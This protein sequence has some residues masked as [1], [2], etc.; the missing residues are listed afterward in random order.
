VDGGDYGKHYA[1]AYRRGRYRNITGAAMLDRLGNHVSARTEQNP[2]PGRPGLCPRVR[3]PDRRYIRGQSSAVAEIATSEDVSA[4]SPRQDQLNDGNAQRADS[5]GI[6]SL[7]VSQPDASRRFL[8]SMRTVVAG[9]DLIR[10]YEVVPTLVARAPLHPEHEISDPSGR[11]ATA[12]SRSNRVW[13]PS[14]WTGVVQ[15][16]AR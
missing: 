5:D 15:Q 7:E 9:D 3:S 11:Q 13:P 16:R 1:V 14:Y 12:I 10:P 4:R 8:R 2:P 6:G